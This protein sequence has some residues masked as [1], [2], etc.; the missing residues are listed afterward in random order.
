MIRPLV[1]ATSVHG[2]DGL[3]DMDLV[4]PTKK[5]ESMHA[6]DFILESA[7][8]YP[9]ELELI[10]LGPATNIALA[11]MK[12]RKTMKNIKH[13]YSMG[14]A[15]F[16]VGNCTPVAEFNVFVDAESYSV[17]LN[18]GIPLTIIGFDLCLG[19]TAF[20]KEEIEYMRNNNKQLKFVADCTTA[21]LNYNIEQRGEYNIDLPDA[22][23]MGVALWDDIV[24]E[25][26]PAYCYC[27]TQEEPAYGQVIIYDV[28][29][30]FSVD[31]NIPKQNAVVIKTIDS[32]KFK[33]KF[34]ES[35]SKMS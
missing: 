15:G 32:K 9:G 34:I 2:E 35:L 17:M 25:E 31:I 4:H 27:C 33:D 16:G 23:A 11:I 19:P 29:T 6:V 5:P 14:T 26:V 20:G 1:T 18:S 12:D 24:L 8:K 28:N 30:P 13:I 22:V 3:G 7:K 21:L 10:V